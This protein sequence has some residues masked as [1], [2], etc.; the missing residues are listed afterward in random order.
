MFS[1]IASI[2]VPK[3]SSY[4]N[5]NDS[6]IHANQFCVISH[7][8]WRNG[9]YFIQLLVSWNA[10]SKNG[11]YSENLTIHSKFLATR[12]FTSEGE[13]KM[14]LEPEL[15]KPKHSSTKNI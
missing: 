3:S 6:T 5:H 2:L 4:F 1:V 8:S 12:L 13:K 14:A 9:N 11:T 10:K 15:A 7:E